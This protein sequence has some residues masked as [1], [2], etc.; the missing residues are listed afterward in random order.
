MIF[1]RT[2]WAWQCDWEEW[3]PDRYDSKGGWVHRSTHYGD[4]E[5]AWQEW[6]RLKDL[7]PG[8]VRNIHI[9][10]RPVGAPMNFL[11]SS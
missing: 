2:H 3:N 4:Y 11:R 7:P 1:W 8:E 9:N 10:R 6:Y 5:A